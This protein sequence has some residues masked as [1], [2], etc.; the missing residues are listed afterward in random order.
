MNKKIN[1]F[2]LTEITVTL[3]I[4]I[5]VVILS[6]QII[7]NIQ[8]DF[9]IFKRNETSTDLLLQSYFFIKNDFEKSNIVLKDGNNLIMI[10]N[11]NDTIKYNNTNNKCIRQHENNIDTLNLLFEKFCFFDSQSEKNN[12]VSSFNVIVNNP[13]SFEF[14]LYKDYN[15]DDLLKYFPL[16]N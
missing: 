7:S 12:L 2:T 8:S 6:Y 11:P 10:K 13:V 3:I 4:V 15:I 16:N 1:S 9:G 14:T 5:I